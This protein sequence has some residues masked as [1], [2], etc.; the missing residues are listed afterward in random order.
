MTTSTSF[1][2]SASKSS[3]FGHMSRKPINIHSLLTCSFSV[4]VESSDNFPGPYSKYSL[5]FNPVVFDKPY[6]PAVFAV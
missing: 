5:A 6:L 1:R 2:F 4:I 3:G